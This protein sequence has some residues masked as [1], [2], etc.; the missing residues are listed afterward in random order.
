[1]PSELQTRAQLVGLLDL[2]TA[3]NFNEQSS[4]EKI[5]EHNTYVIHVCVIGNWLEL[6]SEILGVPAINCNKIHFF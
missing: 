2:N 6:P 5:N 4:V 1:M 3:D